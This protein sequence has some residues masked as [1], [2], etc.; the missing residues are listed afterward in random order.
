MNVLQF[1][2]PATK[3]PSYSPDP[4]NGKVYTGESVER[5]GSFVWAH[6]SRHCNVLGV[7]RGY[8]TLAEAEADARRRAE[9][10]NAV[11]AP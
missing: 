7:G 6:I 9:K 3:A 1:R 11:F 2:R 5:S 8:R 10:F 4:R